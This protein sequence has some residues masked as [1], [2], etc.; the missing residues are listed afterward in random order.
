MRAIY[1]EDMDFFDKSISDEQWFLNKILEGRFELLENDTVI[2][3][4][5]R[6]THRKPGI[7]HNGDTP[8]V[9]YKV[10]DI[11]IASPQRGKR[12]IYLHKF[13]FIFYTKNIVLKN[14]YLKF[15]DGNIGN[16]SFDNLELVYKRKEN[17]DFYNDEISA[18]QWFYSEII[19]DR[20]VLSEN[21]TKIYD[22]VRDKYVIPGEF[23]IYYKD[24]KRKKNYLR[25]CVDSSIPYYK[26][27]YI[28]LHQFV[29][30]YYHKQLIPE[31]HEVH[32][33]DEDKHNNW[34]GNLEL[35]SNFDHMRH[36]NNSTE[37]RQK[38]TSP[39]SIARQVK[40]RLLYRMLKHKYC[41]SEKKLCSKCKRLL[42]FIR[43]DKAN[44]QNYI[45]KL[46]SLCKECKYILY[47]DNKKNI[48]RYQFPSGVLSDKIVLDIRF[49]FNIVNQ[50]FYLV[51]KKYPNI[52]K[53]DLKDII[54]G[55]TY[56]H[57]D[58][59]H[60][61]H[62]TPYRNEKY[63]NQIEHCH[64]QHAYKQADFTPEELSKIYG[65]SLNEII[66]VLTVGRYRPEIEMVMDVQKYVKLYN[67]I[68]TQREEYIIDF[69]KLK[70]RDISIP[71]NVVA[72]ELV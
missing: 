63:I 26:E 50:S 6:N 22:K 62:D 9:R 51:Q 27:R 18:K 47:G 43:F 20:F 4:K 39:E 33:K 59:L 11:K 67:G 1:N 48:D 56:T 58:T 57:I 19:K 41:F 60:G 12:S 68:Y 40:H 38:L 52:S 3:D 28:Q 32:H 44:E 13:V 15:K 21:D 14:T 55:N 10:Y 2:Y 16:T 72:G 66:Y 46:E 49:L 34:H 65:R 45:L 42:P 53:Q 36:H 54:L 64:I 61:I 25:Y 23:S 17:D 7:K 5:V 69:N 30:M 37:R 24:N 35:I 8:S 71:T 29:W 31:G 70:E